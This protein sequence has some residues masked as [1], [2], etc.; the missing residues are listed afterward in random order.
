MKRFC[1]HHKH[2]TIEEVDALVLGFCCVGLYTY[3]IMKRF[4]IHHNHTT[5][6]EEDAL[7]SP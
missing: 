1:I 5:I 7:I 4:F 6:E 3:I 2:T